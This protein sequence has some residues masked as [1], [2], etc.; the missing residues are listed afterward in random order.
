MECQTIINSL[1]ELDEVGYYNIFGAHSKVT[2]GLQ[3][4]F[5]VRDNTQYGVQ[6]ILVPF[7]SRQLG[8]SLVTLLLL[9]ILPQI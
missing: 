5:K 4:L 1:D 7:V 3:K 8:S 2:R 6:R 9:L